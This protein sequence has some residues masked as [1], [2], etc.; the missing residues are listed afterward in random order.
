MSILGGGLLGGGQ[1]TGGGGGRTDAQLLA[2]LR[3]HEAYPLGAL[4]TSTLHSL[5]KSG[6]REFS[7]T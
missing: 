6:C 4:Y 2:F 1:Q 5:A 3:E 7:D